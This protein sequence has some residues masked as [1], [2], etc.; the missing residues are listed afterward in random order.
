MTRRERAWI[1]LAIS[2]GLAEGVL[3]LAHDAA[4]RLLERRYYDT[5]R[6]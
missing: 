5:R 3:R 4:G 6:R 1:I 2:L